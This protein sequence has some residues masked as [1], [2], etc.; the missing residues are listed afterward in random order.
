MSDVKM[1]VQEL[2]LAGPRMG[3]DLPSETHFLQQ[4]E[5][6][7]QIRR[8]ARAQLETADQLRK[9]AGAMVR[10]LVDVALGLPEYTRRCWDTLCAW[11]VEGRTEEA[12]GLHARFESELAGYIHLAERALKLAEI[13]LK[14][15]EQIPGADKIPDAIAQLN[16]L[17]EKVAVQWRTSADLEDLV[18]AEY[19]LPMARL[20]AIGARHPAPAAWYEQDDDPFKLRDG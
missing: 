3:A 6:A 8:S 12:H 17:H 9:V 14:F 7:D 18:A 1:S 4:F 2:P 5:A 16:Q 15:D 10:D 20:D 13:A 11:V 19:R